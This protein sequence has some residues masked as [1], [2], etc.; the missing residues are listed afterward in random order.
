MVLGTMPAESRPHRLLGLGPMTP[1]AAL[2]VDR[3]VLGAARKHRAFLIARELQGD[4][5]PNGMGHVL[6]LLARLAL[7][8]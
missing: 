1:A 3:G 5:G 2:Y 4:P 8:G 6:R 7:G